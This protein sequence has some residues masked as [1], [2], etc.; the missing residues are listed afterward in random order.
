MIDYLL[1]YDAEYDGKYK[2]EMMEMLNNKDK[3]ERNVLK[4]YITKDIGNV[5]FYW[6]HLFILLLQT[7]RRGSWITTSA[8]TH[9]L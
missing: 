5:F 4:T 3:K 8:G 7:W 1:L 2:K 6:T 9:H